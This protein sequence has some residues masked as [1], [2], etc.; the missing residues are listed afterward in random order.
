MTGM[1]FLSWNV[2]SKGEC[3]T[4]VTKQL[5]GRGVEIT[6]ALPPEASNSQDVFL[7]LSC[8]KCTHVERTFATFLFKFDGFDMYVL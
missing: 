2:L 7:R 3:T 4:N 6:S 8:E 1:P 5:W